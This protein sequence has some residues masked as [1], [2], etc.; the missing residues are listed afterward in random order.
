MNAIVFDPDGILDPTPLANLPSSLANDVAHCFAVGPLLNCLYSNVSPV[1]GQM[2]ALMTPYAADCSNIV[3]MSVAM[4]K[5]EDMVGQPVDRMRR[6]HATCCWMLL[7]VGYLCCVWMCSPPHP[8]CFDPE[9]ELIRW[10]GGGVTTLGN[11]PGCLFADG[12]LVTLGSGCLGTGVARRAEKSKPG[13]GRGF[14]CCVGIFRGRI[15]EKSRGF[16]V[17]TA[18]EIVFCV[19]FGCNC[20]K[21]SASCVNATL[22]SVPK[23]A[24]GADGIGLRSRCM[25]S[26]AVDFTKSAD[27]VSGIFTRCGKNSTVSLVCTPLVLGIYTE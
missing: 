11:A 16:C 9:Y 1:V 25:R 2:T 24:N 10:V 26:S 12:L 15:A 27:D 23:V 8:N 5:R 17:R 19:V 22:V 20:A 14:F 3:R 21:T 7:R 18:G 4:E 13:F 6:L